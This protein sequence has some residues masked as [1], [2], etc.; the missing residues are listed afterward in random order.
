MLLFCESGQERGAKRRH[1]AVFV[2]AN[3]LVQ[4]W[5]VR[6]A[7]EIAE[8]SDHDF[9]RVVVTAKMEP[10]VRAR[11]CYTAS[12]PEAAEIDSPELMEQLWR[13]LAGLED[14]QLLPNGGKICL[15]PFPDL[16][17]LGGLT[18][19][20]DAPLVPL[21]QQRCLPHRGKSLLIT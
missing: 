10:E 5:Q 3:D 4:C 21:Q 9:A 11:L 17:V 14:Q 13:P 15:P 7:H 1:P 18:E 20:G 2:K 12:L 16:K 6:S 19:F 8:P